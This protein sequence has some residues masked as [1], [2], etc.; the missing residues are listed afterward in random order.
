RRCPV[1]QTIHSYA[2]RPWL[3][4]AF[5]RLPGVTPVILTAEM[6]RHFAMPPS[7][8]RLHM[9]PACAAEAFFEAPL[10]PPPPAPRVRLLG[11]GVVQPRKKW[12]LLCEALGRLPRIVA[13]RFEVSIYG[14]VANEPSSIA[15]EQCLRGKIAALDLGPF[16]ALKGAV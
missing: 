4:R 7:F 1:V 9:I 2:A 8:P 15:Y 5:A 14:A 16:V 11:L 13:E 12:H 10:V 6:G 3:Y